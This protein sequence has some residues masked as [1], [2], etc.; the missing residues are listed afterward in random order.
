[1]IWQESKLHAQERITL[2]LVLVFGLFLFNL[3]ALF[4]SE[5]YPL[6]FFRRGKANK[7]TIE[8]SSHADRDAQFQHIN[9]TGKAFEAAGKPVISVDCKKELLDHQ[10]PRYHI[11]FPPNMEVGSSVRRI[12]GR[13]ALTRTIHGKIWYNW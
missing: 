11:T 4:S 12:F 13:S 1:M 6:V 10:P 9:R 8:G 5:A 2:F 3:L 7:K